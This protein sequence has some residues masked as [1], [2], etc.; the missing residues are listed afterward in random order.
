M[1]IILTK[2]TVLA[3]GAG[4]S[5]IRLQFG[6]WCCQFNSNSSPSR[7]NR[8]RDVLVLFHDGPPLSQGSRA[9]FFV[10]LTVGEMA[11]LIEMVVKRGMD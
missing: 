11:F 8:G 9:S 5:A 3:V 10:T 2:S 7:R 6:A 4:L 1:S